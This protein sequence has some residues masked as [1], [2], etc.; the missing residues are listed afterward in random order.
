MKPVDR[1][2]NACRSLPVD[3]VPVW[4][5]RQAGR[6]MP[7]YRKLREKYS[8]M[9]LLLEPELAAKVTL[10]PVRLGVD[11]LIIFSDILLPFKYMSCDVLFTENG[12]VIKVKEGLSL[13]WVRS[14]APQQVVSDL[15]Y[16]F[17]TIKL[18]KEEAD[19]LGLALI[20]FAGAPLTLVSYLVGDNHSRTLKKTKLLMYTH[21]ELW[22]K[23]MNK[24]ATFIASYLKEQVKTGVHAVQLFD[25]W[26]GYLSP[27]D[28]N[29]YV[30]PYN[31]Q[32]LDS[33]S[34]YNVPVIYFS[35]GTGPMLDLLAQLNAH[36]Y[37][38]DWRISVR[39]ARSMLGSLRAIQGNL[40]PVILLADWYTVKTAAVRLLDEARP[41]LGYIFNLGHGILPETSVDNVCRL[42]EL[43][44][45]RTNSG[46]P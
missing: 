36:V 15:A 16:H 30:L 39:K 44:H 19:K 35:T 14:I 17:K 9:E 26:A 3:C 27:A 4:F 28:Y 5:M 33:L 11:C 31:K 23:L 25:S 34:E 22:H 42:V 45:E 40:D 1:F 20:G 37:S 13:K 46:V 41:W 12:P 29:E 38:I 10:L 43:V 24:L 2:L 32:I 8:L 6:Y 18:V 7:E 21:K